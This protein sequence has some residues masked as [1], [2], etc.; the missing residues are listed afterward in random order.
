MWARIVRHAAAG[1]ARSIDERAESVIYT[2]GIYHEEPIMSATAKLFMHGRSQAVRLPKEF[3]FEGTE[4][5]VSKVGDK[6]ILEPMAK[7]P[8]DFD[9]FWAKLDALG[10]RDFLPDGIPDD[11]PLEPDPRV[12]FDE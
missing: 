5:R 1:D 4:V 11:P 3:R 12:F 2:N 10:A 7:Q 8:I 6:V 9:K